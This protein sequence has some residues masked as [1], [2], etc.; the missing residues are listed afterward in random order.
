MQ[1]KINSKVWFILGIVFILLD[2]ILAH[3]SNSNNIKWPAGWNMTETSPIISRILI[4]GGIIFL[5]VAY[6]KLKSEKKS[7]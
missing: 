5:I 1:L 7:D 2:P 3:L 4:G 6:I